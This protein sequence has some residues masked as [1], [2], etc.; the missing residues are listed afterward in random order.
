MILS[1]LNLKNFRSHKDTNL[2]FSDKLN[3]II[4]GNGQGKTTVLESIYYL[5]TTKSNCSKS[6]LEVVSF[7][8]TGFEL[9]GIFNDLTESKIRIY[10]S[11][12]ENKKY[13]YRDSKLISRSADIIG[14]FPIVILTP[15]DHS[16]T[17]GAP[18][19]RRKFI[20]SIISQASENYLRTIIDYGRTLRQRSSLLFQIKDNRNKNIFSE[21][22]AWTEKLVESGL[23][24]IN[25]RKNFAADFIKFIVASYKIIMGETEV[26]T[27]R[28]SFLENYG[29]SDFKVEFFRL[30]DLKRNEELRR[31]TNLVG[32]HRDEILFEINNMSLKT[33]GS[34]GQHKTFQVVLRFAEFFYLKEVMGVVPLFLLDDIFGE[35]DTKRSLK[36][37]EY[38]RELG[39]TFITMTD[40]TNL[41]FMKKNDNDKYITLNSGAVAYG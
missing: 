32:P 19:E 18:S 26:P 12:L 15:S 9:N 1:S 24:I 31:S 36:I 10:Y 41:S 2:K 22:D 11:A 27:L 37:S 34:Q 6:D 3:F 8:E 4:G 33:Y 29:G 21:L 25:Y 17:Q 16:I 38:L 14:K 7:N 39:Q 13:Y 30:L 23:I 5:C 40:L 20:D 35:L 28:Y